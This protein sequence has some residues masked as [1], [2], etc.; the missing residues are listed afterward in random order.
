MR[1]H[2]II[3]HQESF[4]SRGRLYP[5]RISTIIFKYLY[6]TNVRRVDIASV[7]C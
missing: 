5:G 7:S 2:R 4:L 6:V 1:P 3:G